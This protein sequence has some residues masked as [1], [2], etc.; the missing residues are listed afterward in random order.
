MPSLL[1]IKPSS[2]GD[3]V[4]GLLVAQ[5]IREQLAGAQVHW[6]ARD[7]FAPLVR[8]CTAVDV[9]HEFRRNDG[10]LGFAACMRSVRA[11]KFDYVL[12]FQGLLRTGLMT[13]LARGQNKFGRSDSREL[14]GTFYQKRA[15]L[16][17]KGTH[18][19]AVDILVR[20]NSLLGIEER[21]AASLTFRPAAAYNPSLEQYASFRGAFVLFPS[22]RRPGKRWDGFAELTNLVLQHEPGARVVWA[23]DEPA[24]GRPGWSPARF[25][26]LTGRTSLDALPDVL[27]PAGLVLGNDSGPMHL[28]AAMGRPVV[29]LFGPTDPDRFGP[30]PPASPNNRV[31]RAPL[32]D[33]RKLTAR[34]VFE[35]V[36]AL[37]AWTEIATAARP[38]RR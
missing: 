11:Q 27:R 26:N 33:L 17:P 25:L 35:T 24:E 28:A 38:S 23:G 32:A 34:E 16:P 21:P 1:I 30:Y 15:P 31:I 18:S 7:L 6:I 20:F 29:A 5:S 2:L 8:Q 13:W 9:V 22:T 3:I 36:R 4:H 14:A 10:L 19:H 37:P 12:D